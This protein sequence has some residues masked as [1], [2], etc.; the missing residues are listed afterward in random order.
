MSNF[1]TFLQY[2]NFEIPGSGTIITAYKL[3]RSKFHFLI[4]CE[5]T[6][7]VTFQVSFKKTNFQVG[8]YS[9]LGQRPPLYTWQ[10]KASKIESPNWK[11]AQRAIL[12]HL[13]IFFCHG[14]DPPQPHVAFLVC[15]HAHESYKFFE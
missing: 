11:P 1:V 6:D 9:F 2:L 12:R 4:L 13:S 15:A 14:N 10:K 8:M 5:T 3:F 7:L